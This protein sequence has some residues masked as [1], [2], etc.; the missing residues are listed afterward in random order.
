MALVMMVMFFMLTD[1]IQHKDV[2]PL[3]TC[4][5]IENLFSCFIPR[6]DVTE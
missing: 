2:Y 1:R 4:A 6:R 5:D 3:L